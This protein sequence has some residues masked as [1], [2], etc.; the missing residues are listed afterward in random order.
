MRV[1]RVLGNDHYKRITRVTVGVAVKEASLLNGHDRRAQVK[2]WSPSPAML[3]SPYEWKIFRW[4]ENPQTNKQKLSNERVQGPLLFLLSSDNK[5][6][7]TLK[8]LIIFKRIW[9]CNF[10]KDFTC[11]KV[12]IW[13]RLTDFHCNLCILLNMYTYMCLYNY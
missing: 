12:L 7:F 11:L 8:I 9:I 13:I 10:M 5:S 6:L 2:I 3:M 1:S 4:D